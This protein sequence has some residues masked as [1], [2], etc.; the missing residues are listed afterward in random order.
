MPRLVRRIVRIP[1]FATASAA[2]SAEVSG[3]PD[4]EARIARLRLSAAE[5]R[6]VEHLL[7]ISEYELAIMTSADLCGR[8]STS[9][10]TID[11]LTRRLGY[12]GLKD[13]RRALLAESRRMHRQALAQP[14][15][16]E[17]DASPAP[18]AEIVRQVLGSV[19]LRAQRFADALLGGPGLG[20]LVDAL[21]RARTIQLFGS[22]ESA[23]ACRAMH[24]RLIRLGLP[25]GFVDDSHTQVTQAALLH[26]G[27]LAIAISN[28]GRT[29]ATNWAASVARDHGATLAVVLASPDTPLGRLADIHIQAPSGEGLFGSDEVM[30]RVLLASLNEILFHCIAAVE[31]GR[32]ART[33]A[34]DDILNEDRSG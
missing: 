31:P 11:R 24:V 17:P 9:R 13:M 21:C 33:V 30:S 28:S 27:D 18:P 25:I 26:A 20:A 12:A 1:T 6:L 5:K 4:F 22:G 23:A 34:I 15:A 3:E 32:L 7:G 10:S 29:R 19:A 14:A 2:V 16:S 8:T